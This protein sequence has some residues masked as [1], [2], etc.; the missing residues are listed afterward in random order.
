M[1]DQ[2]SPNTVLDDLESFVHVLMYA[3]ARYARALGVGEAIAKARALVLAQFDR[4][5][6]KEKAAFLITESIEPNGWY[7]KDIPFVAKRLSTLLPALAGMFSAV[8]TGDPSKNIPTHDGLMHVLEEALKDPE[9]KTLKDEIPQ[10]TGGGL[11]PGNFGIPEVDEKGRD[12]YSAKALQAEPPKLAPA[13]DIIST[14]APLP[15]NSVGAS[16]SDGP[17]RKSSDDQPVAKRKRTES[18]FKG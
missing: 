2:S 9:W 4:L 8:Y 3:C 5:H 10:Y 15:R 13:P 1:M 6:G 14:G 16:R 11:K 18:S 12:S 17:S 7:L